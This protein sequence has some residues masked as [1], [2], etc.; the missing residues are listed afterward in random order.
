MS[1]KMSFAKFGTVSA[2]FAA[3]AIFVD[4]SA[5]VADTFMS[6]HFGTT[7]LLENKCLQ[8][9][10]F[11]LKAEKFVLDP[12]APPYGGRAI[13]TG[14]IGTGTRGDV[15]CVASKQGNPRFFSIHVASDSKALA[16]TLSM[17]VWKVMNPY[18]S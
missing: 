11:A 9:A 13:V 4:T 16:D 7:G 1:A 5:A 14:S 15:E 12:V 3:V 6:T 17:D 8:R 10:Q 18:G 2:A